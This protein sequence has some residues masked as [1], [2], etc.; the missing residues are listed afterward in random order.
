MSLPPP[1]P[2]REPV[3]AAPLEVPAATAEPPVA[4]QADILARTVRGAGWIIGWRLATRLIGLCNTLVLVRLLLPGDF[5]LVSLG[6]AFTT[7]L[8]SLSSIGVEEALIRQERPDRAL[9]DTGFTIN[10]LRGLASAAVMVL[11]APFVAR[12]FGDARLVPVMLAL[13]ASAL[14]AGLVNIGTVEFRRD[15]AFDKEFQLLV[16]PRLVSVAVTVVAAVLLHSYWALVAG[17]LS[18][19]VFAVLFSFRLHP[20]RPRLSLSAWRVLAGFSFWTWLLSMVSLVRD[21]SDSFVIGR[22]LGTAAVGV[23]AV[24]VEVAWLPSSELVEPLCRA[25]FSGFAAAR[26]GAGT[27]GVP[28]AGEDTASAMFLRVVSA[29]LMLT[30]PAGLGLSLVADPVMRIAFGAQWMGAVPLVQVLGVAGTL[31]VLGY[32]SSTLFSAHSL[33][34]A[35]LGVNLLMAALRVGLLAVLVATHGLLGGAVAVLLAIAAE[36]ATYLAL[37]VHR[38]GVRPGALLRGVWRVLAAAAAMA[39]VLRGLGLGWVAGPEAPGAAA[40]LLALAVLMGAGTYALVLAGLWLGCGRPA[41]AEADLLTVL[42]GLVRR[43]RGAGARRFPWAT[44]R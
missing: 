22:A 13:A 34:R 26:H 43:L 17:I 29:M 33:L 18:S 4:E 8:D 2:A 44:G 16:V 10:A 15:I 39:A 36:Q 25:C 27:G 40:G 9:Y 1:G 19:R 24:G 3:A 30:L 42:G 23:Y 32:T 7:A 31:T 6:F 20:Y 28:V 41:G 37:T 14:L 38:F 12:F 11:S 21:R 35:M 5:G